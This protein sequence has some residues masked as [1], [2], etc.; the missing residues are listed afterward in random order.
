M[1]INNESYSDWYPVFFHS[2]SHPACG[3]PS[4]RS[5]VTLR[6]FVRKT[7]NRRSRYKWTLVDKDLHR[8]HPSSL[9]T[10]DP[11]YTYYGWQDDL[12]VLGLNVSQHN[13]TIIKVL[14]GNYYFTVCLLNKWA[15]LFTEDSLYQLGPIQTIHDAFGPILPVSF[16]FVTLIPIWRDIFQFP[17]YKL[18]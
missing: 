5:C 18:L 4:L 11:L 17:K 2:R 15:F 3:T 14:K 8:H 9:R 7:G 1:P 12:G 13:V 10:L 6:N 16:N